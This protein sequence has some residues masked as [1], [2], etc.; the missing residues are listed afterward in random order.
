MSQSYSCVAKHN[1]T[2][3]VTIPL[4]TTLKEKW[5]I[6]FARWY[7][8]G[9]DI[10]WFHTRNIKYRSNYEYFIRSSRD[11]RKKANDPHGVRNPRLKTTYR[12]IVVI[13]EIVMGEFYSTSK[14]RVQK[15]F[16]CPEA[17]A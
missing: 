3:I 15:M 4:R 7:Y 12:R 16:V 8:F 10:K 9:Y 1:S 2:V 14:V 11:P 13:A 17:K 6:T 5:A